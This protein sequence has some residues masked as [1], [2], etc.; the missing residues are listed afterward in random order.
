MFL[1][2][3]KMT[4]FASWGKYSYN[5]DYLIYQIEAFQWEN[6]YCILPYINTEA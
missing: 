4:F 1:S 6:R 5:L 2:K 3:I